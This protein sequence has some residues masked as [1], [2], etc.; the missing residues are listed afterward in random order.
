MN[1][2]NGLTNDYYY[3]FN[4]PHFKCVR[5]VTSRI[6]DRENHIEIY[7][8]NEFNYTLGKY[9]KDLVAKIWSNYEIEFM[10]WD[11]NSLIPP[12]S[13]FVRGIY[14]KYDEAEHIIDDLYSIGEISVDDKIKLNELLFELEKCVDLAKASKDEITK[15]QK[16]VIRQ[17]VSLYVEDFIPIFKNIDD[18]LEL[19]KITTNYFKYRKQNIQLVYFKQFLLL[20]EKDVSKI[21]EKNNCQLDD[22]LCD[23]LLSLGR[24][25]TS[26]AEMETTFQRLSDN[27]VC[28]NEK[29]IKF[30]ESCIRKEYLKN[31]MKNIVNKIIE[32]SVKLK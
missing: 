30:V 7:S 15:G 23:C 17:F 9:I 21:L 11:K 12:Q 4:S 19:I 14:V 32:E 1:E 3:N 24:I 5:V 26:R 25:I 16:K 29:I 6:N 18:L 8:R 27:I 13:N 20:V 22:N 2:I 10:L 28:S 31:D